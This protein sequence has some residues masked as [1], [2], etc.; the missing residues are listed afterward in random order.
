MFQAGGAVIDRAYVSASVTVST[1]VS[2]V[3][4]TFS[5]GSATATTSIDVNKTATVSTNIS[6]YLTMHGKNSPSE[7]DSLVLRKCASTIKSKDYLEFISSIGNGGFFFGQSLQFY[8]LIREKSFRS[9]ISV[10]ELL[11]QEFDFLFKGLY[12]FAQDVFGNQFVFN[13]E[14]QISLFNIESRSCDIVAQNFKE[15]LSIL[16]NDID[17]YAGITYGK[18]W[19]GEYELSLDQRIQPKIPFVIGGE[20]KLDNFYVNNYPAYLSYNADIAKQIYNLK[21]GE[22]VKLRIKFD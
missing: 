21:D 18:M 19:K 17:Y 15:S 16:I 4:K 14:G 9:I 7:V 22:K 13:D 5:G 8:S 12:S 10:N 20:Y 2:E 6:G 1:V 3:K 11:T